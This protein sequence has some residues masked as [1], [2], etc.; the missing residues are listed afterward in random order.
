MPRVVQDR[1]LGIDRSGRT[2]N[3]INDRTQLVYA[4][5]KRLVL[6][7]DA[8]ATDGSREKEAAAWLAQASDAILLR[9]NDLDRRLREPLS[10]FASGSSWP[11][12]GN[13]CGT[14]SP[15]P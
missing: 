13:V 6:Q 10:S 9:T 8:D 1:L 11:A 3:T 4:K 2:C 15:G 14:T 5:A 7:W 12:N